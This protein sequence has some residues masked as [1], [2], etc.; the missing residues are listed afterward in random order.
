MF[1]FIKMFVAIRRERT[2]GNEFLKWGR[3]KWRENE[4]LIWLLYC[5]TQCITSKDTH[6]HM[7]LTMWNY[8]TSEKYT[9]QS[10]CDLIEWINNNLHQCRWRISSVDISVLLTFNPYK[11]SV[12]D[13]SLA[14]PILVF[15]SWVFS[16]TDFLQTCISESLKKGFWTNGSCKVI[17]SRSEPSTSFDIH[18]NR[19]LWPRIIF[20]RILIPIEPIDFE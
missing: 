14:G 10:N 3:T 2:T 11:C 4:F 9:T 7:Y 15:L 20:I 18:L 17:S 19:V 6:T 1:I 8:M 13:I 5:S 12:I 16:T